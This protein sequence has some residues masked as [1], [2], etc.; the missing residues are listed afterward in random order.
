MRNLVKL[1]VA[2][3]LLGIPSAMSAQLTKDHLQQ[4]KEIRKQSKDELTTK[5]T[6]DARKQAKEY[7]K[8]GWQVMPGAL[9]LERQLDRSFLMQ[10]EFDADLFPK[11]LMGH[12]SSIGQNYDAARMQAMELAKQDLAGQIQTEITA[13]VEN[14]V[15]NK[16]LEPE[17]AASVTK[18][19]S[20]SKHLISQSIGRIIVVTEMYRTLSNKNK[21]V[22]IRVAYNAEMAKA[23]AKKAIS[24]DLEKES[25]DL[26]NKL[27]ELLGW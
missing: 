27:D 19:I 23:A 25:D 7:K 14:S 8:E 20:A 3:L 22:D 10:N 1:L 12:A 24:K 16:Q 4:R 11:Y 6:K 15:D 13:L 9:P 5:A 26:H 21:E 18:T 17:E 2:V